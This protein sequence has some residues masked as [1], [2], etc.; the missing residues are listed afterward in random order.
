MLRDLTK[1]DWLSILG[2]P[3]ERAPRAL[4]LRG[5][6]NFK[7][8]YDLYRAHFTDVLDIGSPN[9][10][11]EDFFIGTLGRRNVAYASVYG[12][13]MASEIVHVCGVLGARLV[14]QTG[15]CGALADGFAA[16]DLF[17]ATE[18]YC[19]EGAA[20]YYKTD[21]RWVAAR[22]AAVV[23]AR[24]AG[25]M[26]W[27]LHRGRIYTTGALF[28]EGERE[29]ESW[30]Q[31]GFA[32]VDMETAA[33]FAVA[34]HFGM[35]RLALLYAF[36]NPRQ[37]EHLLTTAADKDARRSTANRRVV[38]LALALARDYPLGE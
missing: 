25:V 5:T 29:I 32:A 17:L 3:P 9:G 6:R 30:Y 22:Y 36:D 4:I 1:A 18:A 7:I 16:G 31:Q 10:V 15:N 34:E 33:T 8:Y 12:A 19:G 23:T 2:V 21:G 38:E 28:A 26:D 24:L 35:D 11:L 27:P 14:V 37:Q 20:Q 13:P